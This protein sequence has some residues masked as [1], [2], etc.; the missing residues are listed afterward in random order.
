MS[1]V[2]RRSF[3]KESVLANTLLVTSSLPLVATAKSCHSN[4]LQFTIGSH[5]RPDTSARALNKIKKATMDFIESNYRNKNL[6]VWRKKVDQ[7]DL[8]KR[9]H[10]AIY[11]TMVAIDKY[12]HKG[13]PLDPVWVISQMM[14][15]SFFYEFAVSGALAVGPCQFVRNTAK[16]YQM[17]CAGDRAVHH[18]SVY[19]KFK[20]AGQLDKASTL[21]SKKRKFKKVSRKIKKINL[22]DAI[23]AIADGDVSLQATAKKQLNY[24]K[25]LDEYKESINEARQ[26][27]K[28]Y[29]IANFE[30]R[31][32]FNSRDINFL[33]NFDE[34][35]SY[36]RSIPNMVK[37]LSWAL[38]HRQG[39]IL[40][41][42]SA[43][44]AGLSRTKD[45]GHFK[46]YGRI[47]GNYET[48]TYVS[49]ILVN[50]MEITKKII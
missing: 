36:K 20:S 43:Y 28:D 23:Q 48:S 42:A 10:W 8:E 24:Q 29:L 49:R 25:Q 17:L 37:M 15:E 38:S 21:K 45:S 50:Y 30:G 41:A 44:N 5:Y 14:V 39:N 26:A 19:R 11:W 33:V 16:S 7:V 18:T 6:P 22:S 4:H 12:K 1:Q 32:I 27:Y 40:V 47:P 31:D 34:R 9:V 2:S 46:P 13:F 3:L 35:I